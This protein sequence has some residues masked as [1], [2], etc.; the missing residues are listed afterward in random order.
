MF[1]PRTAQQQVLD[2][3]G[4]KMGVSAVPGSG[5][6]Q[7]LSFLA[8]NLIAEGFLEEDQEVLIVTLVNSAVNN[9]SARVSGFV[10]ERGLLPFLGYRVRTLHGLAHDVVRER[11]DLAGLSDQFSI[12]DERAGDLI[13]DEIVAAWV[14]SHPA[15]AENF[16][17]GD[18]SESKRDWV[19]RERWPGLI[20]KV[21]RALIGQAKDRRWTPDDLAVHLA[22]DRETRPLAEMGHALYQDYQYALSYRGAVDFADL[23]RLAR[24]A[25]DQDPAF[26]ERLRQRWPV[27]LED[28]AQ[29]SSQLQEDMLRLLSGPEG[30]WVRVGDPNQAIYETFT[31]ADPE[32]LKR[33]LKE[34]GVTAVELPNSGRCQP[35]VIR[36]ANHLID[37]TREDHP[38]EALHEALSPPHIEPSPAGD[39]QPNPPD[40]PN[41]IYLVERKFSPG[42]EVQ[43]VADSLEKWLP[44]HP[45]GTVAVLVPRNDRGYK[46][47]T[48]LKKRRIEPVDFLRSTTATRQTAGAL[49]LVLEALADPKSPPKLAK[50]YEVWRRADRDDE[51]ASIRLRQAVRLLQKCARV[52]DYLWPEVGRDWLDETGVAEGE[53]KLAAQLDAFRGLVRR[54]GRAAALPIDQLVLTLAQDLFGEPS[55][56]ALAHKLA[57]VLKRSAVANPE[58][59]LGELIEELKV[60]ATNERRF[61]GFSD[62]DT[63]FDPETYRG[64][65][66]I[67]TVHKA[68]GL[69]WDRVYLM[70]VN[71]YD[72]PSAQTYDSFIGEPWFVHGNL[73]LE[74]E[75]LAQLDELMEGEEGRGKKG[76]RETA[77]GRAT[78]EAR[79]AYAAERLRLLYVGI[80]RARR[81]LVITWNGGR[82]GDQQPALPLVALQAY[83]KAREPK[84]M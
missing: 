51:A 73:N 65:V 54:W 30:H 17:S 83:W 29:D 84:K 66:L 19:R 11:P 55:E 72:F 37:W 2:F 41:G 36:L 1:K 18:L 12:L 21:A 25:L 60:V 46:L 48:E 69:E 63:G 32:F 27:V 20:R 71:N 50:A 74:A 75:A 4:G 53:P 40:D 59:R 38:V 62:D 57:A 6:T 3:R 34:E 80:T 61:L 82:D 35:C 78:H 68:K 42:G 16:L 79:L 10:R 45:D 31:T 47:I 33:F 26:L 9:F 76:E 28:E 8:A 56:L 13:L 14:K 15:A 77:W 64:R 67:T 39:P 58:W 52:E 49:A 22:A 7:T 23:I 24:G 70:S 5:K 81:E 43:A 44:A